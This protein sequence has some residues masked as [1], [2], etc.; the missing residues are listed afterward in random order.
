M[1]DGLCALPAPIVIGANFPESVF[2]AAG[3]TSAE[4]T[5]VRW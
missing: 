1:A 2:H 3:P 4:Y 5:P